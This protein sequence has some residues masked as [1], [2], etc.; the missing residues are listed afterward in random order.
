MIKFKLPINIKKQYGLLISDAEVLLVSWKRG[1]FERIALFSND[2]AG[3]A[4]FSDFLNKNQKTYK[5]AGFHVVANII[6]EDYRLEKVAHLVGKYKTDFHSR[7]MTQLFRG[8]SLCM[9]DVQGRDE[10]GRREDIVLFYGLLTENK[11]TPWI[12]AVTRIGEI[13]IAGV[14]GISVTSTPILEAMV[15]DWKKGNQLLMILH[16]RGFLRQTQY[17]KGNLRFSRVSKINDENPESVIASV[18]KELERT[19]QY[20]H[21][22]KISVASGISIQFVCPGN[23]IGQLKE[24]VAGSDKIRFNFHDA[25]AIAQKMKLL[26]PIEQLGRDSSLSMHAMFSNIWF[27]QLAPF[28]LVRYYWLRTVAQIGIVALLAYSAYSWASPLS[29]YYEGYRVSLEV[30]DLTEQRNQ[31]RN[32]YNSEL[33][34]SEDPPSDPQNVSAVSKI[35]RVLDNIYVEPTSLLY[36][37]SDALEKNQRLQIDN[38]NWHVSNNANSSD[39]SAE[40]IVNNED[41]YQILEMTGRFEPIVGENYLDVANRAKKLINSFEKRPDILVD[42]ITLPS[43]KLDVTELRGTLTEGHDVESARNRDFRIRII[44]KSYEKSHIDNVINQS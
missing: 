44:W 14:H 34:L 38:I 40:A 26:K 11:V 8:S 16:E 42:P 18:K 5:G 28:N 31:R 4:R 41:I 12:N 32:R 3:I 27:Q 2:D 10:L 29:N 43:E 33:Q 30:S 23:M 1:V 35:F 15:P 17:V 9:S 7:R 24:M 22:L 6:G 13:Y 39:G 25:A 19:I 36:Y 37:V 20:L 21:S